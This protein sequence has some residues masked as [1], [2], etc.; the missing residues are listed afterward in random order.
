MPEFDNSNQELYTLITD[1]NTCL[2]V[3]R[4]DKMMIVF[5]HICEQVRDEI[6][7]KTGIKALKALINK[8]LRNKEL[9][10]M[11]ELYYQVADGEEGRLLFDPTV[12][13]QPVYVLDSYA[14][15]DGDESI[16]VFQFIIDLKRRIAV[17]LGAVKREML[18]SSGMSF[19][20]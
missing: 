11:I 16:D 9:M 20:F 10:S 6:I 4:V 1:I 5:L 14:V 19:N 13:D 17:D 8:T 2:N 12:K 7:E 15:Q 18:R 3:T